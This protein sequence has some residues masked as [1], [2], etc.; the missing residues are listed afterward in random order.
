LTNLV[1]A[2]RTVR[3]AVRKVSARVCNVGWS[4]F[5]VWRWLFLN[6]PIL[7]SMRVTAHLAPSFPQSR[8][9][10]QPAH[11]DDCVETGAS[12]FTPKNSDGSRAP[13][14]VQCAVR[15]SLPGART[16]HLLPTEVALV[17]VPSV[18]CSPTSNAP[19]SS[20]CGRAC[21][22]ASASLRRGQACRNP[23]FS[24]RTDSNL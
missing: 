23:S 10:A 12:T 21:G 13:P 11:S 18:T 5:A 14:V 17:S 8:I 20:A 19:G 15:S 24:S 22:L 1:V 9:S 2:N 7:L 4:F 3:L 16:R 6:V